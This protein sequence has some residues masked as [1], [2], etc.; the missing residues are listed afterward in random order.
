VRARFV[1]DA[2]LEFEEPRSVRWIVQRRIRRS[3]SV[4]VAKGSSVLG[5][6]VVR[7][8]YQSAFEEILVV[9]WW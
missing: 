8:L 3:M 1:I 2:G 9:T 4:E 5:K 6:R 7:P